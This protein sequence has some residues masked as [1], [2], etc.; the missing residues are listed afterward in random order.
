MKNILKTPKDWAKTHMTKILTTIF[1][2]LIIIIIVGSCSLYH[3]SSELE[4]LF[5][6]STS[7]IS[8]LNRNVSRLR[9]E[10]ENSKDKYSDLLKEFEEYRAN[11]DKLMAL[12]PL[13]SYISKDEIE[14]IMKEIPMGSPFRVPYMVTAFFGE[15]VGS[16]GRYRNNHKGWDII[17][18][19]KCGFDPKESFIITPFAPGVVENFSIDRIYGKSLTIRHSERVRTFYAHG[20][21]VYNRAVP[22]KEVDSDTA[23]MFMGNTGSV[24][25]P[26]GAGGKHLH[27][28]LQVLVGDG[29]WKSIDPKPFMVQPKTNA[30]S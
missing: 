4:N 20:E 21:K 19:H 7:T 14:E 16:H 22:G 17:P 24:F 26:I 8:E 13:E 1:V 6:T 12:Q 2:I 27:F 3:Y 28:E 5:K 23:I 9:T 25:S 11:T 30:M 10:R 18:D 29:V 15:S